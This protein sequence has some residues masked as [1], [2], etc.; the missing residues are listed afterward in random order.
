MDFPLVKHF[1]LSPS[2]NKIGMFMGITH[3]SRNDHA[4]YNTAVLTLLDELACPLLLLPRSK[5]ELIRKIAFLGDLRSTGK[6]S[7]TSLSNLAE[8]FGAT[9]TF[10]NISGSAL[11]EM[12][13][14]F[15]ISYYINHGMDRFGS[16]TTELVN[17]A[18]SEGTDVRSLLESSE[19]DLV[20]AL[21]AQKSLL[22][23]LSS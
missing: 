15:A 16:V 19:I 6:S 3:N 5:R 23:Q 7:L 20:A 11:P 21:Q 14:D 9:I 18:K 4:E 13:S 12:D 1:T 22:Y 2:L 8:S 10:F 17:V